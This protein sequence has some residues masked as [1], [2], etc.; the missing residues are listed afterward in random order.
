M[1]ANPRWCAFAAAWATTALSDF[2]RKLAG[3]VSEGVP[4][5]HRSVD[6]DDKTADIM[7]KVIDNTVAA[8]LKYR[9]DAS[10]IA[11]DKARCSPG[12]W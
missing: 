11:I 6:A 3:S 7:V 5:I 12:W 10:T 9:N 8:F 2:K 4:F 1:S